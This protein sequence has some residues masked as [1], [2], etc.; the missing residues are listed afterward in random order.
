M[1]LAGVVGLSVGGH[2]AY[3]AAA[4]LDIPATVIFY[5]GWIPTTDITISQPEPTIAA[6][7]GITGWVLMFIGER[8]P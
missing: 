7:G 8:T 3:L 2:V 5:G 4:H 6:A 1:P